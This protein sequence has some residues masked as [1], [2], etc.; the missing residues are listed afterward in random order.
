M[1]IW[2]C[3]DYAQGGVFGSVW[4][5]VKASNLPVSKVRQ[6]LHSTIPYTKFS[7]VNC[8]FKQTKSFAEFRND[9][10]CL[11]VAYVDKLANNNNGLKSL[12][13]HHDLFERTVVQKNNW[14]K[15]SKEIVCAHLTMVQKTWR[16]FG[17]T[18]ELKK[19]EGTKNFSKLKEN[20]FSLQS[21][22]QRLPLLN[23]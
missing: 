18:G 21:V 8:K 23:V 16:N 10:W 4:S 1:N 5:V 2:N 20:N 7:Q 3:K 17:S 15:H 6:F 12:I 22:R 11:D 9:I 13:V 14:I 19:I